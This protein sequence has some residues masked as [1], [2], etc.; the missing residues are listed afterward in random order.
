[1]SLVL[2]CTPS[3]TCQPVPT[4]YQHAVD[5]SQGFLGA[6]PARP[7]RPAR[8]GGSEGVDC[9]YNI[10]LHCSLLCSQSSLASTFIIICENYSQSFVFCLMTTLSTLSRPFPEVSEP[11]HHHHHHIEQTRPSPGI[12]RVGLY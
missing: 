6:G 2:A 4:D 8:P 10:I 1:M 12:C 5:L 7:A 9:R 3:V 11:H